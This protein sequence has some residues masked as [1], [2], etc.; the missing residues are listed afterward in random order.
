[1]KKINGVFL[2]KVKSGDKE[3]A[4][5]IDAKNGNGSVKFDPAGKGDVTFTVGDDDL[6]ALLTG[7]LNPQQVL[8]D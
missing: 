3:G 8:T 5:V 2:F 1:V 6:L 4:W 7:Q